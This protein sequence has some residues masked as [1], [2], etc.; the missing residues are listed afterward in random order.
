MDYVP[1]NNVHGFVLGRGRSIVSNA[2]QHIGRRWVLNIDLENYFECINFG[3]I[4]GRLQA[5]PYNYSKILSEFIAHIS[6]YETVRNIEGVSKKTSVLMTGGALS[7]LLAN[8][9]TDKLD[10]EL[11]RFCSRLGCSFTRYADDITISS[12][13]IRFPGRIARLENEDD[14]RIVRLNEEFID[15]IESN[16]F[17]INSKK[18]RL[19]GQSVCQEVTGLVV[20]QKRNVRRKFVRNVR[21]MLFD[22]EQ[23]GYAAA[24]SNHL[25]KRSGRGRL[26]A[27]EAHNFEWIVRGKIE[28]IRSVKGSTDPIFKSLAEKFNKQCSGGKFFIPI[29]ETNAKLTECVWHLTYRDADNECFGGTAFA[30]SDEEFVTCAHCCGSELKIYPVK[31]KS[32]ELDACIEK[33]DRV[34]DISIIKPNFV[35]PSFK[36]SAVLELATNEEIERIQTGDIVQVAGFPGNI[37]ETSVTI[38][39][40]RITRTSKKIFEGSLPLKDNVFVLDGGLFEGM[41]GGPV[42]HEGKVIGIIVRG[43]GDDAPTAAH[44]VVMISHLNKMIK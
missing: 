37:N 20:N 1:R 4:S 11:S 25:S 8:I 33:E 18:T 41:S 10:G 23:N 26:T 6:C 34:N 3:R 16:G 36:P 38:R 39:E 9:V 35:I 28:F 21:A 14:P 24:S 13:R 40:A 5:S 31:K 44:E 30:V 29:T 43:P 42:L 2:D 12:N 19:L 32:F 7:P 15:I 17:R 22:W 27:Y